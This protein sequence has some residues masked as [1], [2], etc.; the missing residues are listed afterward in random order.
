[1][2]PDNDPL[3]GYEC[4]ISARD[5]KVTRAEIGSYIFD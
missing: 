5:G 4:R 1:V 3:S 2:F